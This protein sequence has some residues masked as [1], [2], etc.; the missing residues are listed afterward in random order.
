MVFSMSYLMIS[1]NR[2]QEES[3]DR[4]VGALECKTKVREKSFVFLDWV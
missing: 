3:L 1:S 4:L 2:F